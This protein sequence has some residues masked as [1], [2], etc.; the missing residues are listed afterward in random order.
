MHNDTRAIKRY[1]P[2]STFKIPN[3]LI[4]LEERAIK[5][6]YEIIKWD[7]KKRFY[8]PWNK[9]QNLQS[10]IAISCV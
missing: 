7:G 8:K 9:N 1:I 5:D 10:A 2:A 3:T 6:E 4:A